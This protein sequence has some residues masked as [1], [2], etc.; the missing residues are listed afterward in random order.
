MI[1][2]KE[3]ADRAIEILGWLKQGVLQINTARGTTNDP[4]W[5]TIDK[6]QFLAA[7]DDYRRKPE[8]KMRLM[9]VEELPINAAVRLKEAAVIGH[10]LERHI[11]SELLVVSMCGALLRQSIGDLHTRDYEWSTDLKIWNSF[12]VEEKE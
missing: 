4:N 1:V 9:R 7:A 10:I 2:T 11:E 12:M 6:T 3:N 8:P 5:E